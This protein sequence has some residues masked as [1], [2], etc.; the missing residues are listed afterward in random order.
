MNRIHADTIGSMLRPKYLLQAREKYQ[1]GSL[2]AE[3]F[4]E[5]E[6]KAVNECISIQEG[7]GFKII[8]DGEMRRGVFA[9]QIVQS[10]N[11]FGKVENNQVDWFDMEGNRTEDPVTVGLVKKLSRTRF[12]AVEEFSYLRGRTEIAIK[13]TVPSP[14]MYA[15]YWVPGISDKVYNSTDAYLEDV[16][17]FIHEEITELIRQG[18]TYI[19]FDAPELGMMV[20]PHQ[21]EWFR[22]KGFETNSTI[23][24]GVELMNSIIES[25][26]QVIFGLHV[27]KGN[28]KN[29]YMA[30]G[31]YNPVAPMIFPKTKADILLLEYDDIRSGDFKPLQHVPEDK[32]VVLGLISTKK[33]KLESVDDLV[34]RIEDA[35]DYIPLER[36]AISTQCG[37]ASVAE[38]NNLSFT[39]QEAKLKLVVEMARLFWK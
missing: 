37:F 38:G 5:L 7:A 8:S 21:Q 13:V 29:R 16:T 19:Q 25:H 31:G 17:L 32:T 3:K 23:Q 36:L 39:D 33:K 4:K 12:P 9:D 34:K 22:S 6:D 14:T 20:D 26:P 18:A 1:A 2:P 24:K 15:Y 28:D 10:T 30:K 35:N 27:C 11:G